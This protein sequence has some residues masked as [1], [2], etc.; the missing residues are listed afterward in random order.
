[1]HTYGSLSGGA[2]MKTQIRFSLTY[3]AVTFAGLLA[4]ASLGSG[5]PGPRANRRWRA[6]AA[7]QDRLVVHRLGDEGGSRRR[8]RA[9]APRPGEF[10]RSA[11]LPV[12]R[13]RPRDPRK[14]LSVRRRA[15]APRAVVRVRDAAREFGTTEL[16]RPDEQEARM[17]R[18]ASRPFELLLQRRGR[19]HEPRVARHAVG[20]A[21]EHRADGVAPP[22]ASPGK[23]TSRTSSR[24]S[25]RPLSP[26]TTSRR[27]YRMALPSTSGIGAASR[28]EGAAAGGHVGLEDAE[29][30]ASLDELHGRRSS[31]G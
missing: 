10:E 1:M 3:P 11:G 25:Q 7:Q 4:I 22:D 20:A 27:A 19:G 24:S 23:G 5:Q 9:R 18:R 17:D 8:R 16:S 12:C 13:E 14:C 29:P 31:A 30:A 28:G 6:G 15:R 26:T 2:I 21:R